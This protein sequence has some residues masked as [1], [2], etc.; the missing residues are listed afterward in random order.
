[1]SVCPVLMKNAVMLVSVL[2]S[3]NILLL[4]TGCCCLSYYRATGSSGLLYI[5]SSMICTDDELRSRFGPILVAKRFQ[6]QERGFEA[7]GSFR[8]YS[9]DG[10]FLELRG[11]G[12]G[13]GQTLRRGDFARDNFETNLRH[14]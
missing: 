10:Y 7:V 1:M 5:W 9:P 14:F 3:S 2:I 13:W 8:P 6:I 11:Y 4:G 12:I